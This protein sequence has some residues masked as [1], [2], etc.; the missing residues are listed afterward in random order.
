[1]R[2]FLMCGERSVRCI[3]DGFF[4]VAQLFLGF[5]FDLVLQALDLLLRIA[6][7]LASL[8]LNF[9]ADILQFAVD[10]VFAN[11]AKPKAPCHRYS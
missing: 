3:L 2:G 6:N 9:A 11:V 8:F 10:L 7:Q 1:M 4:Q 5:A